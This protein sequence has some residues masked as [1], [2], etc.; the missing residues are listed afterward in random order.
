M[1]YLRPK[2]LNSENGL[3]GL[4]GLAPSS[5]LKSDGVNGKQWDK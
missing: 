3:A 4:A 2:S 5:V 1:L